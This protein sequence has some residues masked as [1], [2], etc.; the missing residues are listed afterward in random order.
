[1]ERDMRSPN[2]W[3]SWK[4]NVSRVLE[5]SYGHLIAAEYDASH[6]QSEG[7]ARNTYQAI[8]SPENGSSASPSHR[9]ND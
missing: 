4:L 9:E 1:M 8:W 3:S 6:P 5:W 7:G 2:Y